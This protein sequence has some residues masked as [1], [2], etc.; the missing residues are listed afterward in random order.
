MLGKLIKDPEGIE[1]PVG[2]HVGLGLLNVVTVMH[3]E[4]RLAEVTG[5]YGETGDMVKG[6]EIHIG[7]TE[8]PGCARSWLEIEGRQEGAASVDGRILGCYIHGLFS[9]DAFR[10][11][12]LSRLGADASDFNYDT[13]VN[14]VL[15]ALAHHIEAHMDLDTLFSLAS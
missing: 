2:D 9:A 11:A 12:F 5:R 14:R 8:G 4:K 1:G 6:Y 15:D 7:K 10:A 3:P 13:E